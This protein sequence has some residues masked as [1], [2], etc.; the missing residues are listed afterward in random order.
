MTNIIQEKQ[1]VLGISLDVNCTGVRLAFCQ[2]WLRIGYPGAAVRIYIHWGTKN[3]FILL[4]ALLSKT[5]YDT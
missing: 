1:A 2:S 5:L 3:S 4:L